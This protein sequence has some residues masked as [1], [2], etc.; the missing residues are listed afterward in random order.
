MAVETG[1]LFVPIEQLAQRA[2]IISPA[3]R[4][5]RGILPALPILLLAWDISGGAETRFAQFPHHLL[6]LLIVEELEMG[7]VRLTAQF[8]HQL[9]SFVIGLLRG[10]AA[11]LDQQP[12]AAG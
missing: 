6:V 1:I 11:E 8:V 12:A 4:R 9:V 10:R 5:N 2:Q 3:L 7:R